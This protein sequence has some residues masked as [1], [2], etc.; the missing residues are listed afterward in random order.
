MGFSMALMGF[1]LLYHNNNN[2]NNDNNKNNW[3]ADLQTL[4]AEDV[5]FLRWSKEIN[6]V[7][8]DSN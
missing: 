6:R 5:K 2:N 3:R 7:W 8:W 1:C 4:Q